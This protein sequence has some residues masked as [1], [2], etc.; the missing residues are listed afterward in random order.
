MLNFLLTPSVIIPLII[1]II[2][3]SIV[4]SGYVKA[5]PDKAIII[6]GFKK[7]PRILVGRAGIKIPFLERKDA[8]ELKMISVDVKTEESVPTNEFINVNID[9]A[10]KV[11]VVQTPEMILLAASNFLNQSEDYIRES[12]GD[13]LQGNVREIIGQMKLEE[14]IQDRKKFADKV[15]ENASPDMAKMGLEIV[16]FNVQNVIDD[17]DVIENLGIDRIVTISKSAQISRAESERDIAI[18]KA[19]A[20]KESNEA[21]VAANTQIAERNNELTIRKAELKQVADAKQAEADKVYDIKEQERQIELKRKE[22]EVKEQELDAEVRKKAEADKFAAQQKSDAELYARQREAEAQLF[23]KEKEAAAKKAEA[24]ALQYQMIKEAE[25]I[26]AKGVAEAE[27]IKA[28]GTAEAEALNKKAD[29]MKKYGEAAIAE[30]FFT[31]WP[32]VVEAAAKP[33]EKVDKITMYGDGNGSKLV[34]DIMQSTS[35]INAGL[36]DSVGIDISQMLQSFFNV[37]GI[38]TMNTIQNNQPEKAN[39]SENKI[40]AAI[41]VV[42][43]SADTPKPATPRQR[44]TSAK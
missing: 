10:V 35:Q 39:T 44:K 1:A 15:Q 31:A 38:Q 17:N 6:S 26:T 32:K 33:L 22:A 34:S 18:A 21:E 2:V 12:V 4:L 14:I 8:L 5:P 42:V 24:D 9:S 41:P 7:N 40:E 30:M 36:S 28:K 3:I 43:E 27:A 16:S 37:K 13:V 20:S 25:G 29:A 23:E 11:K 19:K